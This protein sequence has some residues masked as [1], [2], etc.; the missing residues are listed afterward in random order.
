[1]I[2]Q[3]TLTFVTVVG[4]LRSVAD[5]STE[6]YGEMCQHCGRWQSIGPPPDNI[7]EM[8]PPPLPSFL[9]SWVIGANHTNHCSLCHL[10]A[11][12]PPSTY[13]DLLHPMVKVDRSWVSTVILVAVS[14][15][16]VACAMLLLA[17]KGKQWKIL[18]VAESLLNHKEVPS[19][20]VAPPRNVVATHPP[21]APVV[22]RSEAESHVYAEPDLAYENSG[23]LEGAEGY[24]APLPRSLYGALRNL[25]PNGYDHLEGP[26]PPKG[27]PLPPLPPITRHV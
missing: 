15:G 13:T 12:D 18:P 9:S 25:L 4:V 21:E 14:V 2:S 11:E 5:C 23:F 27:R 22:R 6:M 17:C 3:L 26:R 7:L 8:P 19:A 10:L 24:G 16:V 20:R 1:M